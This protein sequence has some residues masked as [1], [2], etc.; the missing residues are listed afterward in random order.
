MLSNYEV[1][2]HITATK[3]RYI[4]AHLSSSAAAA[5]KAENLETVM[6]EAGVLPLGLYIYN[7]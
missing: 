1:L 5:M 6:R 7:G 3:E 4:A 2:Q